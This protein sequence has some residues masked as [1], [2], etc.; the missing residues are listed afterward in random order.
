MFDG[1]AVLV[2]FG[3]GVEDMGKTMESALFRKFVLV[4][5]GVLIPGF[6][7]GWLL[8]LGEHCAEFQIRSEMPGVVFV[9]DFDSPPFASVVARL[10]VEFEQC[11]RERSGESC[12]ALLGEQVLSGLSGQ[13]GAQQNADQA[14]NYPYYC[15][16]STQEILRGLVAGVIGIAIALSCVAFGYSLAEGWLG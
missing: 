9:E 10:G 12:L 15:F 2:F 5:L 11:V 13:S 3:A 1:Q 4:F 14:A 8:F 7:Y 6:V 16:Q